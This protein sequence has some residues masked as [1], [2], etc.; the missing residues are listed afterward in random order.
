MSLGL[1]LVVA[2]AGGVGAVLRFLVDAYVAPRL[3]GHPW[4]TFVINL[5]GSLLLGLVTGLAS[6]H[7]L[8]ADAAAVLGT[9]LLGGY[10]TFSTA[11]WESLTLIRDT[12]WRGAALHLMGML[13]GGIL[14]AWAGLALGAAL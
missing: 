2:A 10:T 7:A 6:R 13:A 12:R 4:G 1:L 5:T 11:M 8:D 9:G 14:A 3:P